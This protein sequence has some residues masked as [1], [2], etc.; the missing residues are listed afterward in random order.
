MSAGGET[1]FTRL[2]EREARPLASFILALV[3]DRHVAD[4]IFQTTCLELWRIRDT[5]RPGTDFGAWSRTVARYQV[6]RH[7]RKAGRERL[8]FSTEAVERIA[9]AYASPVSPEEDDRL[10]RALAA[11]VGALAPD[12]RGLLRRRYNDGAPLKTLAA[13]SSR[14]EGAIKMILMRLRRRLAA[15]VRRRLA[16]EGAGDG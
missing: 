2:L 1:E 3:G 16:Q 10:R 6:R 8:A 7:W 5:F 12:D 15:C 9:E 4:D 11:C 13:A 14:S